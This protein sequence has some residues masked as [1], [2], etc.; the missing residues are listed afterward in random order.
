MGIILT[1]EE[2]DEVE[3]APVEWDLVDFDGQNAKL[4]M[5]LEELRQSNVLHRYD[6]VEI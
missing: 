3:P 4:K 5:H 2:D 1:S 6:S